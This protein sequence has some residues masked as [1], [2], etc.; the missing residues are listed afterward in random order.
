MLKGMALIPA[1]KT[2]PKSI[3][4]HNGFYVKMHLNQYIITF[5]NAR[6]NWKEG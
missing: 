6:P 5:A 2:H 3:L 4:M 1:A